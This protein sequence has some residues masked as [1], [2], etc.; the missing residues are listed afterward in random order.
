ME[1]VAAGIVTELTEVA[2]SHRLHLD[3]VGDTFVL[4]DRVTRESKR[5]PPKKWTFHFDDDTSSALLV[6]VDDEGADDQV[7]DVF[8]EMKLHL[9]ENVATNK[10]YFK[11]AHDTKLPQ[12]WDERNSKYKL[13]VLNLKSPSTSAV[14]SVESYVF[15][16]PKE[17]NQRACF[18]LYDVY[19][20]LCLSCYSKQPSKWVF[21]SRP[22]WQRRANA[23][24]D[25]THYLFSCHDNN[26]EILG[27]AVAASDRCTK[28]PCATTLG[29]LLF[30]VQKAYRD[31]QG[32]GFRD[33]RA[34]AASSDILASLLH[35]CTMPGT[36]LHF[37]L[38]LDDHWRC[39]WPRP[40]GVSGATK[41][42][43]TLEHPGYIDLRPLL[44][45]ATDTDNM[46]AVKWQIP[47][48]AVGLVNGLM[49]LDDLLKVL[50]MSWT[51]GSFLAQI[52]WGLS[53]RLERQFGDQGNTEGMDTSTHQAW[54]EWNAESNA[55]VHEWASKLP[56]YIAASVTHVRGS[57]H[58]SIPNDE[59]Q[60]NGLPLH[61]ATGV[62]PNNLAICAPPV[63]SNMR[64]LAEPPHGTHM[65][66]QLIMSGWW[67]CIYVGV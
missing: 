7:L 46:V 23:H 33:P 58:F 28:N 61:M 4:T 3:R 52:I 36:P 17:A 67:W 19:R 20:A 54:F 25:G 16:H 65:P 42:Q 13:G 43:V 26:G 14:A 6:G 29:L 66:F 56:N 57:L 8:D 55:S 24:F 30:L 5:L 53:L 10:M 63:V 31:P 50:A 49:R 38:Y 32:G 11:Q 60:I 18:D 51:H 35:A 44:S 22:S 27:R 40:P 45:V 62:Y 34:Q 15:R 59:A 12:S 47:L 2:F 21:T 41:I 48:Q 64:A 1:I 9:F 39:L 37:D